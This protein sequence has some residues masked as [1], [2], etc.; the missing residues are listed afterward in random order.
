MQ[1]ATFPK[2]STTFTKLYKACRKTFEKLPKILQYST[3]KF[4]RAIEIS[5]IYRSIRLNEL[6]L[7]VCAPVHNLSD[8]VKVATRIIGQLVFSVDTSFTEQYTSSSFP[9][10]F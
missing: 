9:C 10:T 4:Q 2:A 5:I 3:K 7:N 6:A 1:H 8:A